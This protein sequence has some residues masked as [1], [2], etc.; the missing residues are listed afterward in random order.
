[1]CEACKAVEARMI[2]AQRLSDLMRRPMVGQA[3]AAA[4]P[5]E[6]GI[7]YEMAALVTALDEKG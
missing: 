3:L 4:L 5:V 7:P 2:A 6:S 1:M